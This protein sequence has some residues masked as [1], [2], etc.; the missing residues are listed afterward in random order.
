MDGQIE[1]VKRRRYGIHQERHIRIDH[2]DHGVIGFPAVLFK[3]GV[4][5]PDLGGIGRWALLREFI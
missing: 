1:F 2:L 5:D 3:I 4:I